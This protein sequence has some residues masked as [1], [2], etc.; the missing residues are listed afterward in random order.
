MKDFINKIEKSSS[1]LFLLLWISSI[2]LV[3]DNDYGGEL[4]CLVKC[5]SIMKRK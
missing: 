5:I 1:H 2:I 4:R 3:N